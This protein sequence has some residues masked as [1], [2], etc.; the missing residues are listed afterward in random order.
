MSVVGAFIIITYKCGKAKP[1]NAGQKPMQRNNVTLFVVMSVRLEYSEFNLTFNLET[2]FRI[3]QFQAL[4]LECSDHCN[5]IFGMDWRPIFGISMLHYFPS[6]VHGLRT[7][8]QQQH[9]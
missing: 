1:P 8:S 9:K 3:F 7:R 5:S 6:Q 4:I 2:Y